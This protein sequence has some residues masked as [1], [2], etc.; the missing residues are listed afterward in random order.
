MLTWNVLLLPCL[1]F[2]LSRE[3][4]C[5]HDTIDDLSNLPLFCYAI[6]AT[7]K[8]VNVC[9]DIISILI[10][11]SLDSKLCDLLGW[12]ALITLLPFACSFDVYGQ[13]VRKLLG[14]EARMISF[15]STTTVE[16]V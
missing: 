5:L 1:H 2:S 7:F 8:A 14:V 3:R 15:S 11:L 6:C 16:A 13:R 9:L 12:L 4:I 10:R